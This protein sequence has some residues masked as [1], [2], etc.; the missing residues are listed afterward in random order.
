MTI[1]TESGSTAGA[2][3]DPP[4]ILF[5]GVCNLCNASVQWVVERD[6]KGIFHL[7]S[8][9]SAAAREV[10][11]EADPSIHIDHLPDS[12][13][14]VDEDGIHTRSDAALRIARRLGLPYSLLWVT[15]LVPRALRDTVYRFVAANRYRWFGRRDTCMLPDPAYAS[16]FLDAHEPRP[17]LDPAAEGDEEVR[18]PDSGEPSPLLTRW[19]TRF[20][21]VY[22]LVYM[23]PF[24]LTLLF[25]LGRVPLVGDIPGLMAVV[26]WVVGLHGQ[27]MTPLVGW[28]G[29]TVFGVEATLAGTGSGDRTFNWVDL[30]VDLALAVILS[31]VWAMAA[32]RRRVGGR[33]LDFSRVLARYYL[34]T[35]MLVYGWVKLFPLQFA[36]PGPDRLI[37]SYGDS[38]PMG[39]AWTFLGGSMGYQMFAGLC[40]LIGGYLLFWRRTA[41]LGALASAAVLANVVAINVFY[42]VPVKLF[43]SHLLL[44]AI[45]IMAPDVPRLVGLFGFGLPTTGRRSVPFWDRDG[46]AR[47]RGLWAVHLV[48]VA[49]LTSFHVSDNLAAS[50]TRGVLAEPHTLAGVYRVESFERAG[51]SG[52]EV[53]DRERW[54]RVGLNPFSAVGTVQWASGDSERMRISLDD[55]GSSLSFYDRGGQ[56]PEDP[57]FRFTQTPA[58]RGPTGGPLRRRGHDGDH[59]KGRPRVASQGAWLPLD[60]RV[61]LQPVAAAVDEQLSRNHRQHDVARQVAAPVPP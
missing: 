58:G 21:I 45:F 39:L 14:L 53:P 32:R 61:P 49:V 4:V 54:V 42:D 13:A 26:G 2:P 47:I 38:S 19:L 40:E 48:F 51:L 34:G 17:I 27:V 22:V 7:A 10:L 18:E 56:P 55:E 41:L 50:R 3:R 1:E 31:V 20:A 46:R 59:A 37:Q 52:P 24:P 60:Q 11:T 9:Q 44:I 15:R 5:D 12:I 23:A 36:L 29:S 43:S 6:P 30:V 28:V 33:T 16:R 57:D 35:T 25:N 8:L